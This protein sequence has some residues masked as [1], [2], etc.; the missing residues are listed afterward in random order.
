MKY[1]AEKCL[2]INNQKTVDGR[3][4]RDLAIK[5]KRCSKVAEYLKSLE[6][7]T[8]SAKTLVLF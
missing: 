7:L 5:R 6:A 8:S 1:F 4:A 3:I 2:E